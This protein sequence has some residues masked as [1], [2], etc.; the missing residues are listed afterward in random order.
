MGD[1]FSN[2][3]RQYAP[4]ASSGSGSAKNRLLNKVK[5]DPKLPAVKNPTDIQKS[6]PKMMENIP[7]ASPN[8]ATMD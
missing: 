5:N 2:R 6:S 1:L 8:V 3:S 4:S 7:P